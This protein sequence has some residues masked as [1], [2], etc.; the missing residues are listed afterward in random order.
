MGI[1]M[2]I[3]RLRGRPP[4]VVSELAEAMAAPKAVRLA[5]NREHGKGQPRDHKLLPDK[6]CLKRR[7]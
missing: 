2:A 7:S 1:S 5:L 6:P 3:G 4:F